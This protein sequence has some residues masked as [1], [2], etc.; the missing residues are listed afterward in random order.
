MYVSSFIFV[1]VLIHHNTTP[2]GR[3]TVLQSMFV[4]RGGTSLTYYSEIARQYSYVDW[5]AIATRLDYTWG[6]TC[7]RYLMCPTLYYADE[8]GTVFRDYL[9][10][11][12]V[13]LNRQAYI[14]E[15]GPSNNDSCNN[16]CMI[17]TTAQESRKAIRV[18]M[19]FMQVS[20]LLLVPKWERKITSCEGGG[21]CSGLWYSCL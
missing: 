15:S 6:A 5:T 20:I 2:L 1:S 11:L 13:R 8:R 7:G 19:Q 18:R 10:D 9:Q 12:T 4:Y 21:C 14:G 17:F 16:S 3:S